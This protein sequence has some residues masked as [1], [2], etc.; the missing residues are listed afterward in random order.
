MAAAW[1]GLGERDEAFRWFER[2]FAEH[3]ACGAVSLKVNPSFDSLR[4]DPRYSDLLRRAGF[5]P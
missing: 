5:T 2:V 1:I 4:D 3:A